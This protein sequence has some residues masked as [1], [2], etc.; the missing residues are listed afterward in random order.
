MTGIVAAGGDRVSNL[1]DLSDSRRAL[2]RLL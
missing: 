2:L 1:S